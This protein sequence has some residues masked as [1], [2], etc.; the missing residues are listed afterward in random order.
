MAMLQGGIVKTATATT[1]S[2]VSA[3]SAAITSSMMVRISH[4]EL[5]GEELIL[6]Q[7]AR[8]CCLGEGSSGDGADGG[9]KTGKGEAEG[10]AGCGAGCGAGGEGETGGDEYPYGCRVE[11]AACALVRQLLEERVAHLL[12]GRGGEYWQEL[13][14]QYTGGWNEDDGGGGGGSEQEEG[15]QEEGKG[16]PEG[17]V[18]GGD[19]ERYAVAPASCAVAIRGNQLLL[20]ANALVHLG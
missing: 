20:L 17:V 5:L 11:V 9:A 8:I 18:I 14:D 2:A 7:L 4:E 13:M 15:K 12:D 3:A 16:A 1:A 10:E 19:G 6:L